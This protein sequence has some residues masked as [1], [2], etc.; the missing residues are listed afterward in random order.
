M[1]HTFISISILYVS[2]RRRACCLLTFFCC[3]LSNV[4]SKRSTLEMSRLSLHSEFRPSV[5]SSTSTRTKA[6]INFRVLMTRWRMFSG[7]V[8]TG[9]LKVKLVSICPNR[10]LTFKLKEYKL[11][12]VKLSVFFVCFFYLAPLSHLPPCFHPVHPHWIVTWQCLEKDLML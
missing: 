12:W 11:W 5:R 2:Y 8:K 9:Q 6:Q 3:W 10:K 1:K 7:T 4:R